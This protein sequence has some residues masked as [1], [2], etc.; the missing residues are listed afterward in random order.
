MHN[1]PEKDH[2]SNGVFYN[3]TFSWF[4]EQDKMSSFNLK[5]KRLILVVNLVCCCES[6]LND[7][8]SSILAQ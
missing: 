3:L 4:C 1:E 2:L 5:N 7:L 8:L 6:I